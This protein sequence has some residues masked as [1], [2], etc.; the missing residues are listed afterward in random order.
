MS[1][2]LLL[3]LVDIQWVELVIINAKKKNWARFDIYWIRKYV[4]AQGQN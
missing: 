1:R 2:I 3:L 4:Y